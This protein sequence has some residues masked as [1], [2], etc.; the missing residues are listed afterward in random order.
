MWPSHC[1][2]FSCCGAGTLDTRA[3]AVA[4]RRLRL[5][6]PGLC[7]TGSTVVVHRCPSVWDLPGPAIEAR[8]PVPLRGPW[9]HLHYP[10][11]PPQRHRLT[12]PAFT[13]QDP[14]AHGRT[15]YSPPGNHHEQDGGEVHQVTWETIFPGQ[16]IFI[17]LGRNKR[18]VTV[19]C[20]K[21]D[22]YKMSLS[23]P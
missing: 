8:S 11:S 2:G 6:L 1:G 5:T 22:R 7:T 4:A 21:S 20:C 16:L 13:Q 12:P 15:R 19:R 3:S 17:I 10:S 9:L 23:F 18:T 14:H